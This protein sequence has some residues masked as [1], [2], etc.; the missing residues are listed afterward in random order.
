MLAILVVAKKIA[1]DGR[2]RN[3]F[4][5]APIVFLLIVT[6]IPRALKTRARISNENM[7]IP[8]VTECFSFFYE[9]RK[10]YSFLA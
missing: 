3:C 5:W 9:S 6:Y 7:G 8:P 2:I 4:V 10:N 1:N